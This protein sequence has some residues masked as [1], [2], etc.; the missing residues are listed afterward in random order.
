MVATQATA[1]GGSAAPLSGSLYVVPSVLWG[2]V[3]R[4]VNHGEPLVLQT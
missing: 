2:L 4:D 1:A 3:Q